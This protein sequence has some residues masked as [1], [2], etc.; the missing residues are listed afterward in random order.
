MAAVLGAYIEDHEY[1]EGSGHLDE[2]NGR[3]AVTPEYPEGT[4]AYYAT[5]DADHNGQYP[6]FYPGLPRRGGNRQ[7]RRRPWPVG[8]GG[9]NVTIEE[10]VET[11]TGGVSDIPALRGALFAYPIPLPGRTCCA[12]PDGCP[13]A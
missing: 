4:Y 11:W 13:T 3:F 7:L 10:E 1:V 9:T 2:F 5:V 8:G 12:S 6:Y